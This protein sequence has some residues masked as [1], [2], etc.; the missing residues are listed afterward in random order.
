MSYYVF[1]N[2]SKI[3]G[4][5]FF[6]LK[7]TYVILSPAAEQAFS[8]TLEEGSV[9]IHFAIE[10]STPDAR[11]DVFIAFF[12]ASDDIMLFDSVRTVDL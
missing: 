3:S 10:V 7:N 9:S 5:V 1:P 2:I 11:Q 4:R 12:K 6:S 8:W